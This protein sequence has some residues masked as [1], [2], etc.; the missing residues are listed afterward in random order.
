MPIPLYLALSATEFSQ[1]A[2]LPENTA[3]LG[4]HFAPN[5]NGLCNLP[6]RLPAGSLLILDD[7][8][9][10]GECDISYLREHLL[11]SMEANRCSGLL[12]DFQRPNDA[13]AAK[14]AAALQSLPYPVCISHLYAKSLNCPVFL[15]PCPLTRPLSEHLAPWKKRTVWLDISLDSVCFTVTE[16][17]CTENLCSAEGS[18]PSRDSRLHCH[19][20]I[21]QEKDRVMFFLRRTVEDLSA[22]LEE[23]QALGV[24]QAVGLWQELS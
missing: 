10:P 14:L 7:Q 2:V 17:G 23:A 1:C 4:C 19:Y 13:N 18:F 16:Q 12:L 24:S 9:P 21:E 3:W 20:R 8:T 22:F 11:A 15:P 6:E 5:G